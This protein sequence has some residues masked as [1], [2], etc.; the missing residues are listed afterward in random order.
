MELYRIVGGPTEFTP[1]MV[2]GLTSAQALPRSHALQEAAPTGAPWEKDERRTFGVVSAVQ[3]KVGEVVGID[4]LLSKY[5]VDRVASAS[6]DPA[7]IRRAAAMTAAEPPRPVVAKT[8]GGPASKPS[9]GVA[10]AS[11]VA[12]RASKPK[13]GVAAGMAVAK[14]GA[15]DKA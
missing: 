13:P 12:S 9:P 15:K 5:H 7:A 3:F 8:S 14:K 11:P 4:G 6:E 10:S 2:L 1:G